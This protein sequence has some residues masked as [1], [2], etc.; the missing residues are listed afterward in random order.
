MLNKQKELAYFL[1][2]NYPEKIELRI[3]LMFVVLICES[4]FGSYFVDYIPKSVINEDEFAAVFA[5][6]INDYLDDQSI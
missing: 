2:Q 6:K 4:H 3:H 5:A 1:I